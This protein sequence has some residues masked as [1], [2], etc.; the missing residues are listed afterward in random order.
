MSELIEITRTDVIE[1]AGESEQLIITQPASLELVEVAQQ[2]PTGP[3]G[4]QGPAGADGADGAD[5]TSVVLKGSVNTVGDLPVG[6]TQGDLYVVL[7]D[8]DG[9]VWNGAAWANVGPI[10][11]PKGDTGATGPQGPKGDT[12]A[13]GA[14]GADGADGDS[15]Y[16][17][18]LAN[19]FVG[20]EAQWLASLVGPQGPQGIQ[21]AVGPQGPQG[22]PG[23]AGPPGDP[24][25]AGTT[26]WAGITDK[27][28]TFA[29]SAHTHAIA[30]VAGLQSNLDAKQD[31][32]ADLTAIAV[33]AGTSGL[34]KKTAANTW[35]LDT[36]AYTTNTGTVTSVGVSVPTG[37][38]VTG[39]P[40]NSSGTIAISLASGYSIPT[41]A[42][43]TN[44][45]AAYGWGN[46]AS[47]GYSTLT[48]GSTAGAA[49]AASGS[50]GSATTAAKS[51]HVHPFPAA[52]NVGAEPAITKSTGFAKW[53]GSAWT[54]DNSTYLTS[55]TESDPTV[56]SHVKGITTTN[57]NNWNTA[58]GWG[59]H[60]SAG[61][62]TLALGTAAGSPLAASGAA[63]SATTAAKSDHVHPFPTAANVGAVAASGGTASGLTLDDGYTEEVFAVTGTTPALSPTNGSIQ[64]WT[65]SG[66]ATPTEGTWAAGQSITLMV[67]DGSAATITW[68]SLAVTWKT[69]GGS[70]PTL[71][72]TGFT[73]IALWKVGS[74]I[75]GARVGDA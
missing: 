15:A 60:A 23:P 8:G 52:A 5:G 43:Q 28:T 73:A 32:D 34:L 55:F 47:A 41:T 3:Q 58:Y 17:V 39:S 10:R 9:Y 51:D 66:N 20:T 30:D 40:V 65:L 70:A 6:A 64:T 74:V 57:V 56:P 68:T 61:Y 12:G 33:L 49:L 29:P 62:S 26:T 2:G 48:L 21:G 35:T 46:H 37:L 22:D 71:N 24:G 50:A 44:W 31:A 69:D 18:A 45:D 1:I 67:D 11:G 4:P 13:T 7:A 38:S 36:T 53:N 75:Y 54:F 25:P 42:K 63:G 16:A 59:N 72:T 19:G 27:P 14:A